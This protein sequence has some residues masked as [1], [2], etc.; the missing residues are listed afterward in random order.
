MGPL[1][2]SID[3]KSGRDERFPRLQWNSRRVP[4]HSANWNP[5][6]GKINARASRSTK[7]SAPPRFLMIGRLAGQSKGG[8]ELD[9]NLGNLSSL[10]HVW[11]IEDLQAILGQSG[12]IWRHRAVQDWAGSFRVAGQPAGGIELDCNLGISRP[13]HTFGPLKT[14]RQFWVD[15]ELACLGVP[16]TNLCYHA[17]LDIQPPPRLPA[18]VAQR[19]VSTHPRVNHSEATW[20]AWSGLCHR[21]LY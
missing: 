13:C 21:G 2:L 5:R 17:R 6:V 10:P 8:I 19:S 11:P 16:A 12:L 9:C 20:G 4:A 14:Y 3:Q 18:R 15:L 1:E 7:H